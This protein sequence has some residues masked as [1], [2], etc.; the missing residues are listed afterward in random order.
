MFCSRTDDTNLIFSFYICPEICFSEV[1]YRTG[2]RLITGPN[3]H[4]N[5]SLVNRMFNYFLRDEAS[6]AKKVKTSG[7]SAAPPEMEQVHRKL[8]EDLLVDG[9][10]KFCT[11]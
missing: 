2:C 3:F 4:S 8:L 5:Y 6:A 9:G 11:K 10:Q 7:T 1:I